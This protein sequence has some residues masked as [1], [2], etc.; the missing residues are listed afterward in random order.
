MATCSGRPEQTKNVISR[1]MY[2]TESNTSL[3]QPLAV[4]RP[5]R[6][7]VF[8]DI[9]LETAPDWELPP[10]DRRPRCD[11]VVVAG[12]LTVRMDRGVRWLQKRF[13]EV[14]VL[15]IAGNHEFW[16]GD[17]DR[18]IEKANAAAAGSNV[19]VMSSGDRFQI[20]DVTFVGDTTWTDFLLFGDRRR[21]MAVAAANMN[22]YRRIRTAGYLQR[23]RPEHTLLRH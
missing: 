12:D 13:A 15:Y 20:G 10:E 9:H 5:V 1:L 7:W 17:L 23:L 14:P 22:D 16:A 18:A 2:G 6:A 8:S 11:V 4:R 19:H 21:A 3:D